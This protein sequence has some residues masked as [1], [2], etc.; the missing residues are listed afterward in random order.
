MTHTLGSPVTG[1]R[2]E[3]R[4]GRRLTAH[5]GPLEE[6]RRRGAR[7]R[8]PGEPALVAGVA[9]RR[10]SRSDVAPAGTVSP[11]RDARRGPGGWGAGEEREPR[12]RARGCPRYW[13]VATPP[14]ASEDRVLSAARTARAGA[15][16]PRVW[17]RSPLLEGNRAGGAVGPAGRRKR[18]ASWVPECRPA[19]GGGGTRPSKHPCLS[20]SC[21]RPWPQLHVAPGHRNVAHLN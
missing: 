15:V 1:N 14:F 5:A 20:P 4:Q 12:L 11:A 18:V 3:A 7:K 10:S 21:P 13:L 8:T 2:C 17:P 16:R 9:G 19:S 6:G